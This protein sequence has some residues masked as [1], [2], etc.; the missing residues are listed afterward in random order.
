MKTADY[1]KL[2]FV[3]PANQ[4]AKRIL[5]ADDQPVGRELIRTILE[6]SGY[7]VIEAA[8]GDQALEEAVSRLPDLILLD[9]HMPRRDGFSVVSELRRDP[10][11]ARTPIVAVTATAMKGS[12]QQGL[13]AGFTEYLTKPVPIETLRQL[14]ARLLSS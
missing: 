2:L 8:D 10:R 12:R 7:E 11:F 5:V 3:P 14:I 13:E 4:S 1:S 9:L 6:S